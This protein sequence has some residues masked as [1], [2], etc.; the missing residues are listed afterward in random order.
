VEF[1]PEW[2]L[3]ASCATA[4]AHPH[5]SSAPPSPR[6]ASLPQ[7]DRPT[8]LIP[9]TTEPSALSLVRQIIALRSSILSIRT[10]CSESTTTRSARTVAIID[11][12]AVAA[13]IINIITTRVN[14]NRLFFAQRQ[15]LRHPLQHMNIESGLLCKR[16]ACRIIPVSVSLN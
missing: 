15:H 16:A 7:T 4:P 6:L 8:S 1:Q 13:L 2:H 3:F 12:S 11:A 14:P 9:S 5:P 10:R